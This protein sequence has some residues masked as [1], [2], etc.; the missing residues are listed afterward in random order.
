M[1]FYLL[2]IVALLRLSNYTKRKLLLIQKGVDSEK[3]VA[4]LKAKIDKLEV[5]LKEKDRLMSDAAKAHDKALKDDQA[6]QQGKVD[7][8]VKAALEEA[9]PQIIEDYKNSDEFVDFSFDYLGR[10]IQATAK[11]AAYKEQEVGSLKAG[12]FIGLRFADPLFAK[13]LREVE[14]VNAAAAEVIET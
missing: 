13:S 7:A 14:Q 12:D 4:D 10:G 8:A 5:D 1:F 2:G 6:R 3:E 9:T 11:W